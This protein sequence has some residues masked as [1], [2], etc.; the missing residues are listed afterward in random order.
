[1]NGD[2]GRFD[3]PIGIVD[4][5]SGDAN[6]TAALNVVVDLV[7]PLA[8]TARHELNGIPAV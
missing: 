5:G 6:E 8:A 2:A 1:M 3:M 7:G 4:R